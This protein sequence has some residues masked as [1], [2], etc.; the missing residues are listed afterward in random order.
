MA[1]TV[2]GISIKD[3]RASV[4]RMQNE[5]E[6]LVGRLRKEAR[7]IVSR[8]RVS[9]VVADVRNLRT[10]VRER[11]EQVIDQVRASDAAKTLSEQ[12]TRVVETVIQRLGLAT[13][14][15][16]AELSKRLVEIEQRLDDLAKTKAA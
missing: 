5:G 16:V 4:K 7:A 3:V 1:E 12:A 13:K 11:A 9:E 2:A 15:D 10:N 14:E 8:P 6:R